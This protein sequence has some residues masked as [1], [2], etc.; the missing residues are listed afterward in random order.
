MSEFRLYNGDVIPAISFG[1]FGSDHYSHEQVSKAVETAIDAG[2]KLFDCAEVYG[3]EDRIG[4]VFESAFQSG[5][6]RR[7]DIFVTSR[8]WNNHHAPGEPAKALKRSLEDLKLSYVDAY[9]VHWPFPNYHA[10][11]CDGDSRNPDP[12]TRS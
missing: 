10:S 12:G 4:R 11:G 6:I 1:T 7:E 3:N 5:K 2:Y 9:F 8:V